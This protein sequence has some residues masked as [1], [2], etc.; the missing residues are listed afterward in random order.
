ML[1]MRNVVG[2]TDEYAMGFLKTRSEELRKES[3]EDDRKLD[4]YMREHRLVSLVKS[5]DLGHRRAEDGERRS[6]RGPPH[7][8]Q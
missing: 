7:S 6:H 4:D 1:Q 5:M 8:H 3:E 2:S